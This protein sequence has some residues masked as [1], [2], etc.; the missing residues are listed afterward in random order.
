MNQ[1]LQLGAN[2]TPESFCQNWFGGTVIEML[3]SLAR[4]VLFRV[5]SSPLH[6]AVL[7]AP[8]GKGHHGKQSDNAKLPLLWLYMALQKC[9]LVM[10]GSEMTFII[11]IRIKNNFFLILFWTSLWGKLHYISLHWLSKQWSAAQLPHSIS[12]LLAGAA[13][14]IACP[15][16]SSGFVQKHHSLLSGKKT[17][18]IH[19]N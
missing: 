2:A 8:R 18:A 9:T 19:L 16:A 17:D 6:S 3:G 4:A 5:S 12:L 11:L 13:Q 14:V 7:P 15:Q 1:S 10:S